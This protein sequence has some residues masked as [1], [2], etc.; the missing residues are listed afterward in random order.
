MPVRVLQGIENGTRPGCICMRHV[1]RMAGSF[2]LPYSDVHS[3]MQALIRSLYTSEME[4]VVPVHCW[5][6]V[7]TRH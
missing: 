7:H 5:P 3:M 6:G 2:R 1:A 4:T